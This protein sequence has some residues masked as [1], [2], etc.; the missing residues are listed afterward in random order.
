MT[1]KKFLLLSLG[2]EK[3]K[4]LA[5][6]LGNKTCKK[7]IDLLAEKEASEQDIASELKIPLNTVEYNLKKLE[8]SGLI[9]KSKS[10]FWSRKGKKIAMYKI[11]NKSIIISPKK[12]N[13]SSKI[14]SILPAVLLGGV[15]ALLIKYLIKPVQETK[16]YAAES[17][18]VM[19]SSPITSASSFLSYIQSLPNWYWFSLGV[20]ITVIIFTILNWRKL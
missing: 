6:V 2:D 9:E 3:A 17:T 7:I 18:S 16:L 20:I 13:I 10:F 1:E 8:K 14:K 11:F 5:D 15:G 4:H 12:A 19:A